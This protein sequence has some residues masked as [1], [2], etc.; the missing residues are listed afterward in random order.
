MIPEATHRLRLRL[1]D[2]AE[3]EAEGTA[4]FI[5]AQ[6]REF[7]KGAMAALEPAEERW[8]PNLGEPKIAWEAITEQ[9]GKGLQLRAKLPA[10]K[11]E[12]DACLVL[13][14]CSQRLLN[15]PKPTATQLG[16]WLRASGYPILRMDRAL[17]EAVTRGDLLSSGSRR[18]RRYELTSPGRMKAHILAYQLSSAVTGKP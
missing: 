16:K 1:P 4:D 10:G 6:R 17:Q 15:Q 14:A 11:T 2:G 3:F 5:E 12:R 13:L 18:A 9:R 8:T 7:M